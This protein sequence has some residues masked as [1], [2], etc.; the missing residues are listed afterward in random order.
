MKRRGFSLIEAV[1]CVLLLAVAVPPV[2]E[3]MGSAG[4]DRADTVN[5]NRATALASLVLETVVADVASTDPGLEPVVL[6][7]PSEYLENAEAG[8][9]SRL[10]AITEPYT[11][12]GL[13]WELQIGPRVAS[14]GVVSSDQTLNRFRLVTVRVTYASAGSGSAGARQYVMPVSVMLPTGDPDG[15]EGA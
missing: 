7:D 10:A 1:M 14:D 3:L 4:E 9:R 5:T 13:S 15:G 6:S 2:L 11:R 8:L 12:A